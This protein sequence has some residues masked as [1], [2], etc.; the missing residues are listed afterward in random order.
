MASTDILSG[1][2]VGTAIR[3]PRNRG[4]STTPP[5]A[6]LRPCTSSMRSRDGWRSA[7]PTRP[8]GLPNP[9]SRCRSAPTGAWLGPG[10]N[11]S[12]GV[13]WT[14]QRWPLSISRRPMWCFAGRRRQG[15][16]IAE[17]LDDADPDGPAVARRV[18]ATS[19]TTATSRRQRLRSRA[20]GRARR[21]R[22]AGRGPAR[23]RGG[24]V[25]PRPGPRCSHRQGGS[26]A[27]L[28]RAAPARHRATA[29]CPPSAPGEVGC[30]RRL[31]ADP[32]P[33]FAIGPSAE[34]SSQRP[35]ALT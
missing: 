19:L 35:P 4:N 26:G 7:S 8:S 2:P 13:V 14:G 6:S 22:G 29:R 11:S 34:S 20:G 3:C 28:E 30:R 27:R 16:S 24:G 17:A 5:G 31:V 21:D 9:R 10:A 33:S 15:G 12:S 18:T 1:R 32:A 25:R 23:G